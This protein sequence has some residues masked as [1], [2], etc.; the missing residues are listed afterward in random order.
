M[1]NSKSIKTNANHQSRLISKNI[2]P[3]PSPPPMPKKKSKVKKVKHT[4]NE[5]FDSLVEIRE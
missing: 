2:S 1:D 3:T 4:K 5:N